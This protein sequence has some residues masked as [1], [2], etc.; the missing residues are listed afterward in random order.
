MFCASLLLSFTMPAHHSVIDAHHHLW[1]YSA[2]EYDWIDNR[3][4]AL[5]RDFLPAEFISELA[6]AAIDG[7]LTVQARQTIEETEW[8][9]ELAARHKEILGVV[10]WAPI[11]SPDFENALNELAA[12][13]KLV[14]VR[15]IV[16]AEPPGFL[17]PQHFNPRIHPLPQ[18]RL[19]YSPPTL[20]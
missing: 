2:I 19:L 14:G 20:R 1:H 8:L 18:R 3:M 17:D 16:Q 15:H 9:L 11:A 7:A 6:S 5:R 4:A 13:P 12:D 10:G